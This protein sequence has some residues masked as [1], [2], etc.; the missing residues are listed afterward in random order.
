VLTSESKTSIE[1][2]DAEGKPHVILRSDVEE[3]QVS[4][5][6]I[7][8]EGFE[9]QVPPEGLANLLEFL[10]TRGRYLPLDLTKAATIVSTTG[11]FYDKN[12]PA[13][14][15][16]FADW[17]PKVFEGVPFRL[18][19]PRGDRVPN[20][21]MLYGPIGTFPPKMPKSVSLACNA[22]AK[23]IHLL[24]G[25]SGWGYPGGREGSVSLTVRLHYA[26]GTTEDHPLKNGIHFADY[27][28]R[29][30]VPESK[31]AFAVRGQQVRYLSIHP[32]R[33]D[34]ITQIEFLKGPDATAPVVLAVT[35]EDSN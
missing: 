28:R 31:F 16:I 35:L 5:K 23:S 33:N 30:D 3:L 21:V 9:K 15:L 32:K 8:P 2:A 18:V 20:V 22:P 29:V 12:A 13:E 34:T 19:D 25:V 1:L 11:M 6:S 10:T 24:S 27:I 4:P 14:R 17:S 26:D 7:M